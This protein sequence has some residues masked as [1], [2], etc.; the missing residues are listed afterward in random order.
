MPTMRHGERVDEVKGIR[1][2]SPIVVNSGPQREQASD[3]ELIDSRK[4]CAVTTLRTDIVYSTDIPYQGRDALLLEGVVDTGITLSF[5]LDH[6]RE[7]GPQSLKVCAI[8]DKPGD[9]KVDVRPDWAI[10]TL[11]EPLAGDRFIVGYGLDHAEQYRG[12]PFLGTIPRPV[13]PAEGRKITI[14]RPGGPEQ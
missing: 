5:L 2:R 10:F 1:D 9:R 11:R 14:S 7:H 3:R 12:L 8:I 6:I 13:G 4:L